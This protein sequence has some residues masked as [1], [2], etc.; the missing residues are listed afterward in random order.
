MGAK[1]RATLGRAIVLQ[2]EGIEIPPGITSLRRFRE[3]ARSDG[4][5]ERGRIDWVDGRMEV[6]RTAED[7][8][9]HGN[10]KAAI[11]AELLPIFHK[12][13]K[14]YVFIEKARISCPEADLS[15]EPDILVVLMHTLE[16]GQVRLI[17]KTSG[18]EGRYVEIEGAPDLVVECVSDSSSAKDFTFLRDA[19]HRAGVR[20]HWIVDAR[21]RSVDFRV[22]LHRKA[23][24]VR[25][26]ADSNGFARSGILDRK[27]RLRRRTKGP[28]LVFFQLEIRR[29]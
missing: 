27:V 10:P 7:L 22:L 19:Y 4:F 24:Y 26:R 11:L 15:A 20:E 9:T 16:A 3:W 8:L 14:G 5:P 21:G 29:G 25:A 12:P 13:E 17:P 23:G 28:G 1:G 2:P 6:D 18:E